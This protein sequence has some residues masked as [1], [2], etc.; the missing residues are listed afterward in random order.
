MTCMIRDCTFDPTVWG[1][2]YET[3]GDH[4]GL[5]GASLNTS[6]LA[7]AGHVMATEWPL[8]CLVVAA[9]VTLVVVTALT[10]FWALCEARDARLM[11]SYDEWMT[12]ESACGESD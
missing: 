12:R 5:N 6:W 2:N 9:C 8:L 11:G 4:N 3:P 7:S 1:W 10:I